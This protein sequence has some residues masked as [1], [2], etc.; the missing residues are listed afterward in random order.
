ML[1][2][3]DDPVARE[4]Y[5]EL[6]AMRGYIVVTAAG[7]RDGLALARRRAVTI[8]VLAVAAGALQLRRKLAAMR[9]AL[10]VH[11]TGLLPLCFDM[12]PPIATQQLH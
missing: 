6:F 9:P 7:S 3:A 5:A 4:V 1:I 12:M 10:R 2:I 8:A 11:V